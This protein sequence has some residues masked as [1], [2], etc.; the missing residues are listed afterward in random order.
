LVSQ[1]AS[2]PDNVFVNCSFDDEYAA[3]F[4]ALIFAI[5]ACGFLPR[6]A[7]EL[8]DGGQPRSEKLYSL[9]SECRYGIH[10]LSRTELDPVHQFPRFNMPLELG[11]SLGARRYGHPP[12][13][14]KRLLVFDAERYREAAR[15]RAPHFCKSSS[16]HASDLKSV[17]SE[18]VNAQESLL[19]REPGNDADS[20]SKLPYADWVP[21]E[22]CASQ[23]YLGLGEHS[24][25]KP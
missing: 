16:S 4:H 2:S 11:I 17:W 7:R 25:A 22:R 1:P 14:D 20:R 6:S 19:S 5:R 9:I 10:D 24:F 21:Q 18:V 13:R 23:A 12:Q 8:D 15:Q 3:T